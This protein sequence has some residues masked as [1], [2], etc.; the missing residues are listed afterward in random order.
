MRLVT[1]LRG[2]KIGFAGP[3]VGCVLTC[4]GLENSGFPSVSL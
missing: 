3:Q 2:G 1:A 4:R